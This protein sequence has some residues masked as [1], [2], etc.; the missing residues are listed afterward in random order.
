MKPIYFPYTYSSKPVLNSLN[1][2][3]RQVTVYQPS[4]PAIPDDLKILEDE[5]LLDI[6]LPV[7]GAEKKIAAVL[8]DYNIWA[9]MHQGR[10]M[11]F[12][13]TQGKYPPF[14]TDTSIAQI[15][16]D[17]REKAGTII[18]DTP[19]LNDGALLFNARVFLLIAQQMDCQKSQSTT[20]LE[21]AD[22]MESNLFK[23]LKG[24][25][26][27]CALDSIPR[28]LT[29]KDSLR[30]YM[31]PERLQAFSHLVRYAEKTSGVYV[32]DNRPVMEYLLEKSP[33]M[34]LLSSTDALLPAEDTNKDPAQRQEK[35]ERYLE[36][37]VTDSATVSG[38]QLA[39]PVQEKTADTSDSLTLY[40]VPDQPPHAFFAE[41]TEIH[42]TNSV[43]DSGNN[44]AIRNTLVCFVNY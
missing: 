27:A 37:L 3:F 22:S 43:S 33:H 13:K 10:E 6:Q 44:R 42:P 39:E 28:G 31:I 25:E 11:A 24:E 32:T 15:K 29:L 7:R 30:D 4:A 1:L 34:K 16:K 14:F 18:P 20:L 8:R 38:D 40:L 21:T 12:F 19:A 2:F 36:M 17:I 26:E 9:G 35:I 23:Q 41:C 5:G